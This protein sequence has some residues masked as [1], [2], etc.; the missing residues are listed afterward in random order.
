MYGFRQA[1]E[2]GNSK[3]WRHMSYSS[4]MKPRLRAEW[5]VRSEEL[6]VLASCLLRPLSRNSVLEEF[7]V[8]RFAVI[9]DE[10]RSR[11]LWR[12]VYAG[13]EVS[14]KEGRKERA[15]CHLRRGDGLRNK[16]KWGYLEEWCTWRRVVD[17]GQS[18]GDTTGGCVPGR[19]ISFRFDTEATRWQ[20]W[21]EP[22]ENRAMDI[23]PGWETGDEDVMVNSVES[24]RE[25]E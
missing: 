18:L 21:L 19:Q 17:Q 4:N 1:D 12:C 16:R 23:K 5:L 14:R 6:L 15:E 3:I 13:V 22:A 20:I 10:L 9:Q 25:V 11:A 8:R 7:S 2:C 24:S